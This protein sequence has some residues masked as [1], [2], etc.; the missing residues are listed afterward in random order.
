[1][2][3]VA[4]QQIAHRQRS[5][6]MFPFATTHGV[7]KTSYSDISINDRSSGFLTGTAVKSR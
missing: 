3:V 4:N 6:R 7:C 5:E 1:M 2:K